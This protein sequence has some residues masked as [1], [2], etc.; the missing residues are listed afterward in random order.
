MALLALLGGRAEN[1]FL[2]RSFVLVLKQFAFTVKIT[3]THT[4][5]KSFL[6][7]CGEKCEYKKDEKCSARSRGAISFVSGPKS[8][9]RDHYSF[10][11]LPKKNES[12]LIDIIIIYAFQSIQR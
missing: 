10:I 8:G 7:F 3:C 6:L 12:I 5:V 11:K 1:F 4:K 9:W 2:I